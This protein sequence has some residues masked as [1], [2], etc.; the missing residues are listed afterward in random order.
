MTRI[1]A[2]QRLTPW[3]LLGA[4]F[5]TLSTLL[6]RDRLDGPQRIEE[7]AQTIAGPALLPVMVVER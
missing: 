4:F 7:S 6:L 5:L 2:A 3:L 1:D